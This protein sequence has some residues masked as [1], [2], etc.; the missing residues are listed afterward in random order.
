MSWWEYTVES[1]ALAFFVVAA[2]AAAPVVVASEVGVALA[3]AAMTVGEAQAIVA[4]SAT[5]AVLA[6]SGIVTTAIA[7][8]D[9]QD[10]FDSPPGTPTAQSPIAPLDPD[11]GQDE[12]DDGMEDVD[13]Q[14]DQGFRGPGS[15]TTTTTSTLNPVA[16]RR[17]D[18]AGIQKT[19]YNPVTG[20]V[21]G[22]KMHARGSRGIFGGNFHTV[23]N[24]VARSRSLPVKVT[25]HSPVSVLG[26]PSS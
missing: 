25:Y 1:A 17:G 23:K 10:P 13:Q 12:E 22:L 21:I 2:A 24:I 11:F 16:R 9:K 18:Y 14:L 7:D 3:G 6:T 5:G 20:S 19:M 4:T 8:S 26:F 15:G